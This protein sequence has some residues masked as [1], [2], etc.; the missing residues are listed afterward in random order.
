MIVKAGK[1]ENCRAA[2]QAGDPGELML[3]IKSEGSL[4][5]EFPFLLKTSIFFSLRLSTNWM[6]LSDIVRV[7]CFTQTLLI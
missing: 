3:E 4:E 1:S 7:I 5:G 6:R 2:Q